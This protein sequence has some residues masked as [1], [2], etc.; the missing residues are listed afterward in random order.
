MYKYTIYLI[1]RLGGHRRRHNYYI[2]TLYITPA[3]KY[4][5]EETAQRR[6]LMTLS[7]CDRCRR[8]NVYIV[9]Y[10]YYDRQAKPMGMGAVYIYIY[11]YIYVH[12]IGT[13]IGTHYSRCIHYN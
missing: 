8:C 5:S 1:Y 11:I 3:A 10:G 12:R 2:T 7:T 4:K 9:L 6:V 13:Y